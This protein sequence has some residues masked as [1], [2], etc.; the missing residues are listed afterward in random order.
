MYNDDYGKALWPTFFPCT[1]KHK[2]RARPVLSRA[3]RG[4]RCPC[5]LSKQWTDFFTI[6]GK[7]Y[8]ELQVRLGGFHGQWGVQI[9]LLNKSS[10]KGR[11][12]SQVGSSKACF[13]EGSILLA[14]SLAQT[15][16][17][18]P[19]ILLCSWHWKYHGEWDRW[20]L[21]VMELRL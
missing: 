14:R 2:K 13:C 16:P 5:L 11:I 17:S 21:V 4:H 12:L 6:L 15:L 7:Q 1:T 18:L 3:F 10:S 19:H 9:Y 8:P 20:D